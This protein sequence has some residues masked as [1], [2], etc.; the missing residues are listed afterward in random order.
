MCFVY[1]IENVF[2]GFLKRQRKTIGCAKIKRQMHR[3][4]FSVCF[5]HVYLKFLLIQKC[6]CVCE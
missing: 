4:L 1:Y 2:V 5:F 6:V 3:H